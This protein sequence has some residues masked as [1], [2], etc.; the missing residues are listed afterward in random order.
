MGKSVTY[1]ASYV[2]GSILEAI[3][4]IPLPRVETEI[5]LSHV[6]RKN[7]SWLLAHEEEE[8]SQK[9]QKKVLEWVERRK[10]GEPVAYIIEEKEFYGRSFVVDQRVMIPRPSTEGLVERALAVLREKFEIR[11]SKPETPTINILDK[12]I[13]GVMCLLK[14][15]DP[16][17]MTV[18]GQGYPCPTMLPLIVDIGTGSGCIAVTL[19]CELPHL[20]LI[21]TD[22]SADA[23]ELAQVNARKNGVS[24]QIEFRMGS[25][26]APVQDLRE[27]FLVVANPPYIA[28]GE[29][30]PR[31]VFAYEPPAALFAGREG[32]DVLIPL[33]KAAKAHPF[34]MGILFECQEWQ[35][36]SLLLGNR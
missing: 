26:L 34:C 20:R 10:A 8:I 29:E 3:Q 33:L 9:Q 22:I 32:L 14:T 12:G 2:P 28:E 35:T 27:P 25:L 17:L 24:N 1:S 15:H 31:E 6:L 21:A 7:R 11:I 16:K 5:L 36:K 23:L 30:L 13:A 4:G 18:V 19:A